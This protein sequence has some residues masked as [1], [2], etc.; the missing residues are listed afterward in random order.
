M[1]YKIDNTIKHSFKIGDVVYLNSNPELLMTITDIYYDEINVL[2]FNKVTGE[3]V[4]LK[5]IWSECL[6][7]KEE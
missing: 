7:K 6:T 2:Y 4:E 3:F 5:Y 1:E